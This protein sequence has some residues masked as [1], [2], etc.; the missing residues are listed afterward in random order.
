MQ[1]SFV[2]YLNEPTS[3]EADY[4]KT[5]EQVNRRLLVQSVRTAN[6]AT[7]TINIMQMD[8]NKKPS[9]CKQLQTV[10]GVIGQAFKAIVWV[11]NYSICFS[12]Q[13]VLF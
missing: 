6:L 3:Y 12:D 10:K 2:E 7:M 9:L 13:L 4:K 11:R 8:A 5:L 1:P